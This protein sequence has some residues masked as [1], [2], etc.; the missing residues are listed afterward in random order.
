MTGP[1]EYISITLKNTQFI[2]K[3]YVVTKT[4]F[5]IQVPKRIRNFMKSTFL[6]CRTIKDDIFLRYKPTHFTYRMLLR[7]SAFPDMISLSYEVKQQKAAKGENLFVF[8][9]KMY[10]SFPSVHFISW[11]EKLYHYIVSLA[12]SYINQ[13]I[14]M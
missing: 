13:A 5:K 4:Y 7:T 11:S 10:L 3:I 8:V 9:N 2:S 12:A 1:L 14:C 6:Y